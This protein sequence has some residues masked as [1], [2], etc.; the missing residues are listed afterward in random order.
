M[1]EKLRANPYE[2]QTNEPANINPNPEMTPGPLGPPAMCPTLAFTTNV[3]D[4]PLPPT[5]E[6]GSGACKVLGGGYES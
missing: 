4:A 1:A 3:T 2:Q 6:A 5:A